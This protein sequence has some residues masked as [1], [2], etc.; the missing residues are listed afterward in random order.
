M[1]WAETKGY[2]METQK[3][4]LLCVG[5]L[6]SIACACGLVATYYMVRFGSVQLPLI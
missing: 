6:I 3:T 5:S 1:I 4:V 2:G